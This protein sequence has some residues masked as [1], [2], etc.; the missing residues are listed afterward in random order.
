[1]SKQTFDC[2]IVDDEPIARGNVARFVSQISSL[3]CVG[4]FKNAIE[5]ISFLENRTGATIIFLDINMP[6][7]SGLSM[8][9]IL[10]PEHQVIFTTAYAEYAVKSYEYN[11]I[12]YLLKPFTFDRFTQAVFK[13]T[14]KL[15]ISK[16]I[17]IEEDAPAELNIYIKSSGENFLIELKDITHCEAKKNYTKLF[18]TNERTYKTLVSM[19]KFEEEL[20]SM[21]ELFIRIHR[22]YIVSRAHIS[23]IG[24]S[25]VMVVGDK[26]PIGPKYRKSFFD[27]FNIKK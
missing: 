23:S 22:S 24:A 17:V 27:Q 15:Q 9:K 20:K 10:K 13:A 12:D 8:A 18:L 7:L 26:I 16:N 21:S 4:Q 19:S 1:M 5:A 6:N 25:Y 2:L 11:A 14:K 3:N